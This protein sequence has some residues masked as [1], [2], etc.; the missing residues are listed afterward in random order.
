MGNI[1]LTPLPSPVVHPGS[2]NTVTIKP[3]GPGGPMLV[4]ERGRTMWFDQLE[5]P[6][7]AANLRVQRYRGKRV[8]TWW[9]GSVTPSAFGLGEGVIADHRYRELATVGAGN[10]Y[11]MDI[12]EFTLTKNGDALFPIYSPILIHL[13]G[14]REG[15]LQPLLD[16]IVQQVDIRTGLVVWEWHAYGHIPLSESH[17]TPENSASYD[18][19]HINSIQPLAGDKVLIS[20]RDTS[21]I[22]KLDRS[23]GRIVWRLGGSASDFKLGKGARFHFQ[24]DAQLLGN[25]LV[26]MFDDEAGP[27]QFAPSSRGLVLRVSRHPHKATVVQNYH[28]QADTSAQSEGSLQTLPGNGGAFVGWGAE[29]FFSQFSPR[30]RLLFDANLPVDDGSYRVYRYPWKATP[31]TPPLAAAIRGDGSNVAVYA[32]WNGATE[33]DS[34]RVLAGTSP[35]T[36]EPVAKSPWRGFETRI[37]VSSSATS[38]AVRAL[39]D[40]GDELATSAAVSPR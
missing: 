34:W 31:Q 35:E 30:G 1:L 37:D 4:D 29:P 27:P 20:A 19:F 11:P 14:T 36:L 25:G 18:A 9:R 32:S 23:S 22:Y 39:D 17:A 12:H 5:P 2:E 8:L 15:E 40:E 28:R 7:V 10:G 21:A 24:H 13:P 16:A 38:F 26:S 33:V 3:V 6:K